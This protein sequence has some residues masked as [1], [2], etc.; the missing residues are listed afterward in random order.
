MLRALFVRLHRWAGLATA[1]FLVLAAT[2]GS[3]LV[4]KVELETIVNPHLF[5]AAPSPGQADSGM[6][7]AFVLRDT[8]ERQFPHARADHMTF[9]VPGR[10]AM[11]FLMP[12]PDP[13]TGQAHPRPW[14]Q[15]FINPHTG[16]I[17]GGRKWGE[18][19]SDGAF[20]KANLIPFIWRLHEAVALPHPWGKLL[21]GVIALI[22][23]VDCFIGFVLTLPRGKPFG[24]KWWPAWSIKRPAGAYRRTLDLHRAF[25]LWLWLA[26]LVFAWS[27]VMLNLRDSVYTPVMETAF[28]FD[29]GRP[30]PLDTPR[31]TPELDWR[32]AH[33]AAI[34]AVAKLAAQHGF[35][36]GRPDSL[37]YRPAVGAYMYRVHSDRDLGQHMGGVEVWIDGNTGAVMQTRVEAA[38]PSGNIISDWLTALHVADVFGLPYRLFVFAL[39]LVIAMLSVTGVLIWWKKRQARTVAEANRAALK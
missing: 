36:V 7:D 35:T 30:A 13:S 8:I 19:V 25:S 10:S 31:A 11:F 4:F 16:D 14:D 37:W 33:A 39:G 21:V 6:L 24:R 38:G 26:L 5:V 34:T 9:P 17:L 15:V 22:W 3:V 12:R 20:Q 27:S 1:L 2:T 29:D 28:A 23:T 32:A 18:I